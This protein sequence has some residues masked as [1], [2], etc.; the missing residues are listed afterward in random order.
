MNVVDSSI[1]APAFR[2]DEVEPLEEAG[3]I[4]LDIACRR[5]RRAKPLLIVFSMYSTG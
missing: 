5:E 2:A 1:G 3:R 4:A